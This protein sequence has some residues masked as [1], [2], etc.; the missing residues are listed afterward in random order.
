MDKREVMERVLAVWYHFPNLRLT[1][2][3][4][5]VF[6]GDPYHVEDE[7]LVRSLEQYAERHGDG[8]SD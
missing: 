2:L 7:E 5:N 3:I 4:G 1:Q 8:P 6:H